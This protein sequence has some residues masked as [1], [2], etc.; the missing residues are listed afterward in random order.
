MNKYEQA[1][2]A[3]KELRDYDFGYGSGV[4]IPEQMFHRKIA[5]A[6]ASTL[7]AMLDAKVNVK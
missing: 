6:V 4:S 3:I 2:N 1:E 5:E 7:E